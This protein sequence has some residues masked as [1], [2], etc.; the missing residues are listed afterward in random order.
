MIALVV[1]STQGFLHTGLLWL[2]TP[3]RIPWVG[4]WR[5]RIE[6]HAYIEIFRTPPWVE[7]NVIQKMSFGDG[8]ARYP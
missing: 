1:F 4:P 3:G 7:I 5:D 6:N 2:N 8:A